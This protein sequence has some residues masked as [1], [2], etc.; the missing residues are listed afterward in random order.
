[1]SG[2]AAH[3]PR[4][5]RCWVSACV[6]A[7]RFI[8]MKTQKSFGQNFATLYGVLATRGEGGNPGGVRSTAPLRARVPYI[9][10]VSA[11]SARM[12]PPCLRQCFQ[13]L[14]VSSPPSPPCL[15][16]CLRKPVSANEINGLQNVSARTGDVSALSPPCLR[17]K[18]KDYQPIRRLPSVRHFVH[19][20]P[21][22]DTPN[23][24]FCVTALQSLSAR[25]PPRPS[26]AFR[27]PMP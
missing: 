15:R 18:I 17:P 19:E 23:A 6:C 12:S 5:S 25:C 9:G 2:T 27:C 7:C 21:R 4:A 10:D 24:C 14:T 20:H 13:R 11:V 16:S 1:M 26:A 22:R 8:D 3:G